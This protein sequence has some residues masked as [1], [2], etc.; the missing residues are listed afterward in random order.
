MLQVI[1]GS[2]AISLGVLLGT[3]M[4]GMCVGSLALPYFISSRWH[5]L[6]VYAALE[7]GIAIIGILILF[8]ITHIEGL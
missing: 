2:T 5:P 3:F 1:V 8:S 7:L 4:G 6:K